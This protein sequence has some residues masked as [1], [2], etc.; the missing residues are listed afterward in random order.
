MIKCY[1]WEE[2]ATL[3]VEE[4]RRGELLALWRLYSRLAHAVSATFGAVGGPIR[5]ENAWKSMKING[6]GVESHVFSSKMKEK[7]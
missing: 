1:G 5:L 7:H 2:P 6:K 4:A 3:K